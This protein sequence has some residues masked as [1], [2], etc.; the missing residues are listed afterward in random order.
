MP[1]LGRSLSYFPRWKLC[2]AS[3]MQG[4]LYKVQC[5]FIGPKQDAKITWK[6]FISIYDRP[7][8]PFW[9]HQTL[10]ESLYNTNGFYQVNHN[11]ILR[12]TG[13]RY[14]ADD[15][16]GGS[17]LNDFSAEEMQFSDHRVDSPIKMWATL[18]NQ[19]FKSHIKMPGSV[20]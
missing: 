12:S 19:A 17:Q 3:A 15:A 13:T 2:F 11:Q 7:T 18:K 9:N 1:R 20:R 8:T 4:I 6:D 5:D 14:V 16:D 10:E